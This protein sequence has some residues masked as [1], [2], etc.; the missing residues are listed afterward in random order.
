MS[1]KNYVIGVYLSQGL[2]KVLLILKDKPQ[3]QKGLYNF[4][5]GKVE[6]QDIDVYTCA[7]REFKEETGLDISPH[8][9][10][11]VGD[12]NGE[13][14]NCSLLV[15]THRDTNGEAKS[16][17]SEQISWHE[18]DKLPENVISN[19]PWLLLFAI[20]SLDYNQADELLHFGT[21]KYKYR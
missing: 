19:V 11:H 13:G 21:F 2:D 8:D 1:Y 14:Y 3:W 9:W 6:P 10:T 4:P 17:E 5:G 7:S 15:A 12:I 20:D 16:M 18:V